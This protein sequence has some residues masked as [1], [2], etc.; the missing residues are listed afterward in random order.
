MDRSGT[1]YVRPATVDAAI[2]AA[3]LDDLDTLVRR[4]RISK[5]SSPDFVPLECLVHLIRDARRKGDQRVMSAIMPALLGRCETILKAKIPA[6]YLPNAEELREEIL[7]EFALLFAED[8]CPGTINALDFFECRFNAA[9]L[10]FRLPYVKR[11][12]TRT[13]PL[14]FAP[15][16]TGS[17]DDLTDDDFFAQVSGAFRRPESQT[18]YVLRRSLLKAIDTLPADQRKAMIL[19]HI[20]ELPE[21]SDD[22]SVTTVASLCGVTGRTIRNRLSRALA[23]LSKQFN[24]EREIHHELR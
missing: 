24:K 12:R 21:E 15:P 3:I 13:E 22:P 16:Q 9:F 2:D 8:G 5:R 10:T 20:Y 18:D 23:A 11:E 14:V 17:A 19:Y 7:G 6:D 1:L 4:A